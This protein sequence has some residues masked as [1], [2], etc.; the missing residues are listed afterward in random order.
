M[1]RGW[2][3]LDTEGSRA[4]PPPARRL[5]GAELRIHQRPWAR[6]HVLPSPR[7]EARGDAPAQHHQAS[8]LKTSW[9]GPNPLCHQLSL[10][11]TGILGFPPLFFLS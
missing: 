1:G 8:G 10:T 3:V 6:L 7:D 4:H 9:L 5:P 2:T 11:L